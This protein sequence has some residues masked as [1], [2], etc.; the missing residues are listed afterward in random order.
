VL[1]SLCGTRRA[2]RYCPALGQQICAV[3]CGTKRVTEIACPADCPYL[4]AAREH[5]AAA[6]VRRQ[7]HDVGFVMAF[8]RD[9]SERQSQLFVII[10]T[11]LVRTAADA[12][13]LQ[14]MLD[15]DVADAMRSLA[16]TYETAARG[17]I[18]EHP[19]ASLPAQRIVSGLK[20]LLTEAGQ[21]GGTAF[22]RDAAVVM[23]RLEHAVADVRAADANERRAFI[24]LL[25]RIFA[26][27][28]QAEETAAPA[29]DPPRLIVP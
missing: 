21:N 26:N 22:E 3:C 2:K 17:V 12:A 1:C 13:A 15:E 11:F 28:A 24:E 29:S 14:P 25:A 23:R 18:Y 20:P 9:F 4:A 19:A 8:V 7:R 16:S 6:I 10:A 27:A 5:P